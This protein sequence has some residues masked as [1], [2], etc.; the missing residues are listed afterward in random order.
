M[1]G[2][3][4]LKF[5]ILSTQFRPPSLQ[6]VQIDSMLRSMKYMDIVKG[7]ASR[8]TK[9]EAK[10]IRDSI[11]TGDLL[12]SLWPKKNKSHFEPNL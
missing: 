3:M 10:V 9:N 6:I 11:T 5:A 12:L 4:N 8:D 7:K 1:H 2:T